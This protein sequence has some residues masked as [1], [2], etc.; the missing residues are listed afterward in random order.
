MKFQA[1]CISA[2]FLLVTICGSIM[3]SGFEGELHVETDLVDPDT[4]FF[5]VNGYL[6]NTVDALLIY[7]EPGREVFAAIISQDANGMSVD[8]VNDLNPFFSVVMNFDNLDIG[9]YLPYIL[10]DSYGFSFYTVAVE[11][12]SVNETFRG[13]AYSYSL[14]HFSVSYYGGSRGKGCF[15]VGKCGDG[16]QFQGPY[17]EPCVTTTCCYGDWGYITCGFVICHGK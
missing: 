15:S 2:L 9:T 3:A 7:S 5:S 13:T 16:E 17:C 4:Y 10:Q 14:E 12:R 8:F 1:I 11:N 6:P